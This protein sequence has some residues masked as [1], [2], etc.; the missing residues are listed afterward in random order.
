MAIQQYLRSSPFRYDLSVPAGHSGDSVAR[1]LFVTKR[2]YCEQFAG[3][4]AVLAR[5]AGLPT[6][7]AVGFTQGERDDATGVS[8]VRELNAHAWPEVF[9]GSAGWV[10]FEPT[11][12]RGIPGAESYTG[13]VES[14]ADSRRPTVRQHD[15]AH[16]GAGRADVVGHLGGRRP[17]RPP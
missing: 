5:L 10:A 17:P 15:G 8:T 11:P 7:V 13:A 6:R 14:Q 3:T 1:F 4:F 16:H 2:G 9:L 12:G